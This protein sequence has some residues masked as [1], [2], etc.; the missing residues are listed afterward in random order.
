MRVWE[1]ESMRVWEYVCMCVGL[2][3]VLF[4]S[5]GDMGAIP[6]FVNPP[7]REP[8]YLD[9]AASEQGADGPYG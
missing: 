4:A 3:I 7:E 2:R 8:L 6:C 1:Y 5:F 9:R